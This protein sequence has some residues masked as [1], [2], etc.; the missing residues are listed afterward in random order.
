[1]KFKTCAIVSQQL[2]AFVVLLFAPLSAT[3]QQSEAVQYSCF[4][5]DR[6]LNA[7][8]K[9]DL[10]PLQG[11]QVTKYF[12]G[13]TGYEYAYVD[14]AIEFENASCSIETKTVT[15]RSMM[16]AY[17][18]YLNV[19]WQKTKNGYAMR[20]GNK[21]LRSA[22]GAHNGFRAARYAA[23]NEFVQGMKA[24]PE[25]MR[26]KLEEGGSVPFSS[27]PDGMKSNVVQMVTALVS[28]Y[29][30]KGGFRPGRDLA[31]LPGS[32][33]SIVPKSIEGVTNYVFRYAGTTV[34]G[35]FSFNDYEVRQQKLDDSANLLAKEG[36]IGA[37]Y[38]PD[39]FEL[40]LK[41]LQ[42]VPE[43]KQTV[44]INLKGATM[45]TVLKLLH[46]KYQVSFIGPDPADVPEKANISLS[47]I[48]LLEA[49][50]R[51]DKLYP[52]SSW[53]WNRT[54]ILVARGPFSNQKH[55]TRSESALKLR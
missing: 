7:L 6:K 11:N 50:G 27:L 37:L 4:D 54:G 26:S 53:I 38:S 36:K 2:A 28:E 19:K 12:W 39:K 40:T 55:E 20:V 43:L 33:I 16:E 13:K 42:K 47:G 45:V 3:S 46:N 17:A 52:Q 15:V 25:P 1:M 44:S 41:E 22:F 29:G 5:G 34:S 49:M 10:V 35:N 21:E 32:S 24:L 48:T 23:G 51:L 31:S 30:E 8:L 14:G 18:S 9:I